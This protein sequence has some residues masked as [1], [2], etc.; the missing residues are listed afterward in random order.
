MAS[1]TPEYPIKKLSGVLGH[2]LGFTSPQT[3]VAC[4][5]SSMTCF[6]GALVPQ[7]MVHQ[8]VIATRVEHDLPIT[9]TSQSHTAEFRIDKSLPSNQLTQGEI[10]PARKIDGLCWPR[11]PIMVA[12]KPLSCCRPACHVQD[13]DEPLHLRIL[14]TFLQP[15]REA[16]YLREGIQ[17]S[18]RTIPSETGS[19]NP[20]CLHCLE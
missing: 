13:F 16:L 2:A 9:T 14:N 1:T 12:P 20:S 5:P 6:A 10:L 19:K 18:W 3:A 7:K 4:Q 8:T 11:R 17:T 15:R